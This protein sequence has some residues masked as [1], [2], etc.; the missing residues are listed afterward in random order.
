[1]DRVLGHSVTP[2]CFQ[3]A[4]RIPPDSFLADR[5]FFAHKVEPSGCPGP[6]AA[7]MGPLS[8]RLSLSLLAI[9]LVLRIFSVQA[10]TDCGLDHVAAAQDQGYSC[11]LLGRAPSLTPASQEPKTLGASGGLKLSRPDRE[12]QIAS[13]A[14]RALY[15]SLQ[16]PACSGILHLRSSAAL[17]PNP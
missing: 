16:A 12:K 8:V 6:D 14:I 2:G 13:C 4:G 11:P 9:V 1:M 17:N 15:C 10:V 7:W 5:N 3:H